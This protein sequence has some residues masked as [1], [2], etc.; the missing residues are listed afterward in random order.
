MGERACAYVSL[1]AHEEFSFEIMITYL[2]NRKI[3]PYKLPERLEIMNELPARG[4]KVSKV[5][6][7][8]DIVQKLKLERRI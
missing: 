4:H 7:R 8:E 3:A 5:E 2:K 1:H 6:L